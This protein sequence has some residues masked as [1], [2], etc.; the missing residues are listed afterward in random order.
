MPLEPI[1]FYFLFLLFGLS[2]FLGPHPQHEKVPKLG[3][4]FELQLL[5]TA[6]AT[7][8]AMW[9]P[10]GIC[11]LHRSPCQHRISDPLS[12]ASYLTYSLMD[13]SQIHFHCTTR[14]TL[15]RIYFYD[16]GHHLILSTG[17]ATSLR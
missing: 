17:F 14:G 10:S 2:V 9:D 15:H 8:T 4:K 16:K 5:A 1:L 6:T 13:T 11:D 12:K 3:V 7:A